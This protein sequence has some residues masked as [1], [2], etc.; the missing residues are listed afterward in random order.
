MEIL[1]ALIV[2]L[3]QSKYAL[4]FIGCFFEGSTVMM[5]TG[6]LWRLGTVTF[7]SAY[8]T[9]ILADILSDIMWYLIGRFA[10]R[11]F[12]TRWGYLFD[13]TPETIGKVEKKFHHYHTKILV[14]SKLTMGFG[15]AVPIQV[16]AGMLRV[17]FS[18][19]LTINGL[20][21]LVW[22]LALM[23]IGYYFGNVLAYIPKNFQLALG[24]IVVG[25]FLLG[26]R[27]L[28]KKLAT[29]DW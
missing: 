22:V 29:L 5:A 28:S 21:S 18:R 2:F 3:E 15:L 10:A 20:G 11:S 13:L 26:L 19:Y 9:L 7:W 8:L 16:V 23:S 24:I 14:V 17:P 12:F 6:L 4:I 27:A 1:S 25:A